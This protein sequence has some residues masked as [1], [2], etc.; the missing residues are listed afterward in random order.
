[1][2]DILV[3]QCL[4]AIYF[5]YGKLKT[6]NSSVYDICAYEFGAKC[7]IEHAVRTALFSI[8]FSRFKWM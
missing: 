3:C 5:L 2:R 8:R 6:Q 1:M 4:L 7:F